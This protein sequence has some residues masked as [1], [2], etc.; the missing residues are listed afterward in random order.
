MI[1]PHRWFDDTRAVIVGAADDWQPRKARVRGTGRRPRFR[2]LV[3]GRG[4]GVPGN[5]FA[6]QFAELLFIH[7]W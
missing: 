1:A 5:R 3:A 6:N 7:G 4:T 2:R